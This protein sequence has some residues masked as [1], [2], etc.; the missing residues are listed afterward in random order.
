MKG[1]YFFTKIKFMSNIFQV[2]L[3][4][5]FW[6]NIRINTVD[7]QSCSAVRNSKKTRTF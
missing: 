3:K 4:V 1:I 7:V 5:T 2:L 6:F